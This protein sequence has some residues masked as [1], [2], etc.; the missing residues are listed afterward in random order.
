M[1]SLSY[2]VCTLE[3]T[4]VYH[5]AQQRDPALGHSG[6]LI[7]RNHHGLRRTGLYYL[8]TLKLPVPRLSQASR[9][10]HARASITSRGHKKGRA[11]HPAKKLK[12]AVHVSRTKI[13][14]LIAQRHHN[15]VRP[16]QIK[17]TRARIWVACS[18]LRTVCRTA[19]SNAR[20]R[21]S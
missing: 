21:R 20:H 6:R 14:R 10:L 1:P 18:M 9:H 11:P 5:A 2:H 3:M 8:H 13:G 19:K 7:T 16:N 15:K 12:G 17:S 4:L